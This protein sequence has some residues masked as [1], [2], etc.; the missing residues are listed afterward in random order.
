MSDKKLSLSP[1]EW[2]LM[3]YLW[4]HSPCTGRQA[5]E[6]CREKIGW[7]RT[8]TLTVL[9]RLVDKAAVSCDESRGINA[10]A[11]LIQREAAALQETDDFLDRVYQGSVSLMLSALA[12]KQELSRQE[13]DELREILRQAEGE[14]DQ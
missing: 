8:T 6:F 5:A 13:I 14:A 3:E 4:Q 2:R 11:P 7:S 12:K 9:R 10:Y 1:A